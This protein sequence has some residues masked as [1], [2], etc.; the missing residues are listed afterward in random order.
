MTQAD[1]EALH[2]TIFLGEGFLFNSFFSPA[3]FPQALE[4][5]ENLENQL[6]KSSMHGKIMELDKPE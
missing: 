2:H 6:K 5:M 4:I 1:K 3:G